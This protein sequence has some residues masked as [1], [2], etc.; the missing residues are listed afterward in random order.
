V[1]RRAIQLR[2]NVWVARWDLVGYEFKIL[3]S[4]GGGWKALG[5]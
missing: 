5:I 3:L 2:E 1:K 4:A